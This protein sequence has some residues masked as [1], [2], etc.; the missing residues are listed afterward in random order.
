MRLS[1]PDLW[2]NEIK[3]VGDRHREWQRL[4]NAEQV[5]KIAAEIAWKDK[6]LAKPRVLSNVR[7]VRPPVWKANET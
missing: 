5:R 7:I 6:S 2:A 3:S 1:T 4:S